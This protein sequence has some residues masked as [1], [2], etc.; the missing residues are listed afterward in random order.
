M[1]WRFY[2]MEYH[3]VKFWLSCKVCTSE[4][5]TFLSTKAGEITNP[6]KPQLMLQLQECLSRVVLV[7]EIT[8]VII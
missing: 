4:H 5:S 1:L 7:F 2:T 3:M 8:C 6:I